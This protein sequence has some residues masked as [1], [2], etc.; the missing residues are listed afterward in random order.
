MVIAGHPNVHFLLF[1]LSVVILV[2]CYP[3]VLQK[4]V[5]AKPSGRF[6]AL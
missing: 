2:R 5:D 3:H 4:L 6:A 1:S